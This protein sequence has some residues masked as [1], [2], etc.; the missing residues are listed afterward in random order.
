MWIDA[1]VMLSTPEASD[2]ERRVLDAAMERR[3]WEKSGSE[4][5]K[6]SF[7]NPQSDEQIVQQVEQ[8]VRA[9]IYVAG[10]TS[11]DSV[12]LLSDA[13]SSGEMSS[14]LE[15]QDSDLNLGAF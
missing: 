8:D 2:F 5:Y 9:S 4:A 13:L 6:A 15:N 12:C 7:T 11:F 14:E 3:G 1:L 10:I